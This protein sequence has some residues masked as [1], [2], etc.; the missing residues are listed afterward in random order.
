MCGTDYPTP[1]GTGVRDYINVTDLASGHIAA[2]AYAHDRRGHHVFN[3][4]SGQGISVLEMHRAFSKACGRD[5]P[6]VLSPRR[7]GDVAAYWADP[8]RARSTLNWKAEKSLDE[9]CQDT[10][11]WQSQ[12]PN[13]YP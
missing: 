9:M 12:N 11:R 1:A 8:Q 4:G 6:F 10:W 3:L 7:Q 13:G 5:L 2:L